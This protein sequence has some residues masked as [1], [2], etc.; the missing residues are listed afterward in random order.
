MDNGAV[1]AFA[2]SSAG[3]TRKPTL[4][5]F[6]AVAL[7]A[8]LAACGGGGGGGEATAALA[9]AAMAGPEAEAALSARRASCSFEHVYVTVESLRVLQQLDSGAQWMDVILASPQRIDLLNFSGGLLQA[10]GAAPLPS[11]HYTAVRLMLVSLD[12]VHEVQP[13]AGSLV[14]LI[15]PGGAQGGLIIQGDF[16]VPSGQFGDIALQGF[17]PCQS[18]VQAGSRESPRYQLKPELG[19]QASVVVVPNSNEVQRVNTTTAGTQYQ[20]SVARLSDGGFVVVWAYPGL[21]FSQWCAQRYAADGTRVGGEACVGSGDLIATPVVAGLADGGYAVAW[22]SGDPSG[23]GIWVLQ[24]RA[25]GSATD[26]AHFVNTLQAGDQTDVALA[27]LTGGGY[28]ITWRSGD[29]IYARRYGADGVPLG[30]E[31]PVNTSTSGQRSGPAIAGLAD[32]SYV[33]TW[34]SQGQD[35]ARSVG[36]YMQ[37]FSADGTPVGA[38]TLVSLDNLTSLN[39]AVAGLTGGGFV[40][41]W[42][43]LA[44]QGTV[45]VAQQFTSGGERVGSQTTVKP[46]TAPPATC[47]VPFPSPCPAETQMEPAVAALEDGG[48]VITWVSEFRAGGTSAIYARRYAADGTAAGAAVAVSTNAGRRPAVSGTGGGGFVI[49]WDAWAGSTTESDVFARRYDAGGLLGAAT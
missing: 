18:I 12:G 38:E 31:A 36:I 48:Y 46:I 1:S 10:L 37:R 47:F 21:P 39:P 35:P 28:V 4:R 3:T 29:D 44:P 24:Y 33:I 27:A 15:A 42:E 25:D 34:M 7:S 20:A 9:S 13:T 19:V 45:I 49:A 17:E 2:S 40:I 43:S 22:V 26:F 8:A 32:G 30:P 14:P 41:T 16:V 5:W 11:G 6:A 23:T